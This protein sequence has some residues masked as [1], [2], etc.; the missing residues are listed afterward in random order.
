MTPH[1]TPKD[2]TLIQLFDRF[3]TDDQ[4]RAHLESVLWKDG[5]VCPHCKCK[6]QAKFCSI[7]HNPAKKVRAGLR[8]CADCKKQFTVT[9]G[10]IFE[11]SHIPLRKWLVAW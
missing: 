10:T 6:D 11:D 1:P 7:A 3:G 9:I 8:H 4:A 5:I 2:L